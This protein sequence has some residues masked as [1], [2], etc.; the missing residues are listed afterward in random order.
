MRETAR[1]YIIVVKREGERTMKF[2]T[3]T[4]LTFLLT[5]VLL[6]DGCVPGMRLP[7]SPATPAE[8]AGTYDLLLYGCRYPNDIKN[9]AILI[10][11]G[12]RYPVEIYDLPTS[13]RIERGLP[14]DK[15]LSAAD[16]FLQ[17]GTRQVTGF[18]LSK[19]P[20]GSGGTVGY[21]VR[22]L[23]FPLEFGISDV[24][25]VRYELVDG[26]VRVYVQ[27]D[28]DVERAIESWGSDHND[29]GR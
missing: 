27:I 14:A 4:A 23:Y 13:Y 25:L 26:A 29:S 11:E 15:A 21:E 8:I 19:I 24:L 3:A 5:A 6:L 9:L 20:D 12:S 16:S 17:C 10:R 7:T 1:G 2:F 18:R 28:P 22:A